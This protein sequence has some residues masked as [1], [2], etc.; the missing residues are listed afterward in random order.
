VGG[1]NAVIPTQLRQLRQVSEALN[2]DSDSDKHLY[3]LE[4]KFYLY[5][6]R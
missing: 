3:C 4:R 6:C 5:L 1:A 2:S